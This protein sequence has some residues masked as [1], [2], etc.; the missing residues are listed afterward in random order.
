MDI[1]LTHG[2]FI[3]EDEHEQKIMKPYPPLG[4][5]Y[6]SSHL[7]SAGFAVDV[8]DSTFESL[9]AFEAYVTDTRPGLV[10]IY[11]NLMTKF[12]VLKM[13]AI[14]KAVGAR[15][16]LGGP[17]P[18]S[19]AAEYL[20]AGA[21]IV[22]FGEGELTLEELIPHLA[23][24]GLS[25][26][27]AIQGIIFYNGDGELVQTLPRPQIKDLSTQP[28]PDREAIALE[29]YLDTWETHHGVRSVSLITARGCPYTCKWCSH[30]VSA[31]HTGDAHRKMSSLRWRGFRSGISQINCGTR[32]MC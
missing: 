31:T 3:A 13:I 25:E 5:L 26:L 30:T 8:W 32:M 2:Y 20:A 4:L 14:C 19:Y 11:C 15:V 10:G 1:L 28:W 12:N 9:A 29:K 21:D 16:V 24:K 7:K 23:Q 17:E 27:H 6:V 22:I 18:V